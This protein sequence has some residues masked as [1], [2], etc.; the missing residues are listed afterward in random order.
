MNLIDSIWDNPIDNIFCGHKFAINNPTIL[1]HAVVHKYGYKIYTKDGKGTKGI[2][3]YWENEK[4][5]YNWRENIHKSSKYH[6]SFFDY[7]LSDEHYDLLI[8]ILDIVYNDTTGYRDKII[9]FINNQNEKGDTIIHNIIQVIPK[10]RNNYKISKL[11]TIFEKLLKF[12]NHDPSLKGQ[13]GRTPIYNLCFNSGKFE[14]YLELY[15]NYLQN[16]ENGMSC[17]TIGDY[18]DY[19]PLNL[20]AMSGNIKYLKIIMKDGNIDVNKVTIDH[21]T[22][23]GCIHTYNR[24]ILDLF[25]YHKNIDWNINK[26]N[27]HNIINRS[28]S[29]SKHSDDY[30]DIFKTIISLNEQGYYTHKINYNLRHSFNRTEYDIIDSNIIEYIYRSEISYRYKWFLEFIID[31]IEN[32]E[33]TI[34]ILQK[35]MCYRGVKNNQKSLLDKL[36]YDLK[37]IYIRG[38]C[39]NIEIKSLKDEICYIIDIGVKYKGKIYT[40]NIS[41]TLE[42]YPISIKYISESQILKL[43]DRYITNNIVYKNKDFMITYEITNIYSKICKENIFKNNQDLICFFKC[44]L[45]KILTIKY[46]HIFL[47]CNMFKNGIILPPEIMF[48]IYNL[49]MNINYEY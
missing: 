28:T 17:M 18:R 43:I 47:C 21:R 37:T 32:E 19:T 46:Y 29:N 45:D 48:M 13:Y 10:T 26:N 34:D 15:I 3:I 42:H 44:M 8:K 4:V 20:F 23:L 22:L 27:I 41:Y 36:L 16:I 24:E 39:S 33:L 38:T 7:L 40:F 30:I 35:L 25:I 31:K 2:H 9:T 49:I 11:Y 14:E 12:G 6:T 5:D 1:Y